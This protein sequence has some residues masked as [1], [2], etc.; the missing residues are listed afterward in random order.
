MQY[1]RSEPVATGSASC[2]PGPCPLDTVPRMPQNLWIT[3]LT[4]PGTW[5]THGNRVNF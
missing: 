4:L 3:L 2:S 5:S 1:W